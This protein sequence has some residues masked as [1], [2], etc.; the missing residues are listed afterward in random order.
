MDQEEVVR[1]GGG[2]PERRSARVGYFCKSCDTPVFWCMTEHDKAM[3]VE[4]QA[5]DDGNIRIENRGARDLRGN[6]CPTAIY[7]NAPNLFD[8]NPTRYYSH[9]VNC[10][11][12]QS[13]RKENG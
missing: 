1:S 11:A 9:F 5:R 3:L 8:E 2:E 6:V 13:H 4:A 10:P 12:A 7:D